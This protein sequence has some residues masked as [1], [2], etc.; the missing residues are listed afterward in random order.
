MTAWAGVLFLVFLGFFCL[1]L[2]KEIP[3]T[4]KADLFFCV[5]GKEIPVRPE[6]LPR[7][8]S[9]ENHLQQQAGDCWDGERMPGQEAPFN[10]RW[11]NKIYIEPAA[12][13]T[14]WIQA[15]LFS[16]LIRARIYNL[17][18]GGEEPS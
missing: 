5:L 17:G 14:F 3:V 9:A 12:A 6:N 16:C 1:F 8:H 10:Q 4:S 11:Q 7:H 13:S 2:K 15:K 18:L